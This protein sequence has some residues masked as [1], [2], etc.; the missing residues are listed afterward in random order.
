SR[1]ACVAPEHNPRKRRIGDRTCEPSVAYAFK[2]AVPT[3]RR[4]P[5]FKLDVRIS[6][7]FYH[8]GYATERGHVFVERG[9]T[10]GRGERARGNRLCCRDRGVWKFELGELLAVL[11]ECSF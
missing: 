7:R 3:R 9:R 1:S 6:G 11:R 4:H 10:G 5:Y 2:P 8:S